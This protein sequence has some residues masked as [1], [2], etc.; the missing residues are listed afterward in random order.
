MARYD[1]TYIPEQDSSTQNK[2]G[3]RI[4][5]H[6]KPEQK[7]FHCKICQGKALHDRANHFRDKTPQDKTNQSKIKHGKASHHNT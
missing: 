4:T 5:N 3:Q 2:A 7:T 1:K 6:H